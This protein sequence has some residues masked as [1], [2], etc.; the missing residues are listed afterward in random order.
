MTFHKIIFPG[1]KNLPYPNRLRWLNFCYHLVESAAFAIE[2][3][4]YTAQQINQRLNILNLRIESMHNIE[5]R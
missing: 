5:L 3:R 4:N 2:T 1:L